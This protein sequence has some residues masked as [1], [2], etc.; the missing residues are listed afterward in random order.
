MAGE[1]PLSEMAARF[2]AGKRPLEQFLGKS[3]REIFSGEFRLADLN[4]TQGAQEEKVV[5]D[6]LRLIFVREG[7]LQSV[8]LPSTDSPDAAQTALSIMRAIGTELPF[9][10]SM[11]APLEQI[12]LDAVAKKGPS[13]VTAVNWAHSKETG[14]R[15]IQIYYPKVF[16]TL[17]PV[18]PDYQPDLALGVAGHFIQKTA[19]PQHAI[20]LDLLE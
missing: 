12:A 14:E 17:M 15:R 19:K 18:S 3:I 13:T 16:M 5:T 8:I 4:R 11:F 1:I 2:E 7:Q 9:D 20:N 10:V 6:I